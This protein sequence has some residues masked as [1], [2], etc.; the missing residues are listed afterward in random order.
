[1]RCGGEGDWGLLHWCQALMERPQWKPHR[2]S[3]E[4]PGHGPFRSSVLPSSSLAARLSGALH[5]A[6]M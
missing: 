6:A 3:R 1:M 5:D 4:P 2:P